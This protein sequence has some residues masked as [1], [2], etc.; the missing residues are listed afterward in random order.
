MGDYPI[1]VKT[2]FGEITVGKNT[3][4]KDIYIFANGQIKKR[5]KRYY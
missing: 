3:Y 5:R 4:E 1:I 2:Q